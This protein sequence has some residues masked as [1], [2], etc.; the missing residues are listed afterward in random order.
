MDGKQGTQGL[1]PTCERASYPYFLRGVSP[2]K[3]HGY[4]VVV[5]DVSELCRRHRGD[6]EFGG[7]LSVAV[8]VVALEGWVIS[9]RIV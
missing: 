7:G 1:E 6:L 4:F 9:Q 3:Y 8:A 2:T 5:I